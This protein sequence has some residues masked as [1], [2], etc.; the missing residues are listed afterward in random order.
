MHFIELAFHLPFLAF[1]VVVI[2]SRNALFAPLAYF[3]SYF[4]LLLH[5]EGP[6]FPE[7]IRCLLKTNWQRQLSGPAVKINCWYF[8]IFWLALLPYP[9]LDHFAGTLTIAAFLSHTSSLPES[10]LH[11]DHLDGSYHSEC[12]A[13]PVWRVPFHFIEFA[14]ECH[15][16][17]L[18]YYL[19]LSFL[20]KD[21]MNLK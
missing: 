9:D 11:R 2:P 20:I 3:S 4:E 15:L 17:F 10:F 12:A 1:D 13:L 14:M 19:V 8:L 7:T 5:P 16:S 18:D 21:Q 6:C